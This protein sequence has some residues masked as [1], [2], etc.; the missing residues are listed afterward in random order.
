MSDEYD[1]DRGR[2]SDFENGHITWLQENREIT[3]FMNK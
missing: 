3:V 1:T 2:Q